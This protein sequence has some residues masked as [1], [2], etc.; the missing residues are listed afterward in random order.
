MT[1][2]R[3]GTIWYYDFTVRGRRYA[4]STGEVTK[5]KAQAVHD[6]LRVQFREGANI[7]QVWEQTKNAL[8]GRSAGIKVEPD[9]LWRHFTAHAM[10]QACARRMSQYRHHITEFAD[11]IKATHGDLTVGDITPAIAT[12]YMT[13]VRNDP[14]AP[15]SKNERLLALKMLFQSF[16][17]GQGVIENPFANIKRLSAPA[18]S[19]EIFSQDELQ[20]IGEKA[21]GSVLDICLT[22]LYTGLRRGDICNLRWSSV[23]PDFKWIHLDRMRKTGR[24]VDIPVMPRLQAHLAALPHTSEYVY[25]LLQQL[26]A[27]KPGEI[28]KMMKEFLR[29][30]GILGIGKNVEGY[31]RQ[32]SVKDIHSFRHTFVYLAACN[33]IPL[34]IVQSIVG[35]ASPAMTKIYMDHANQADKQRFMA[36][37]PDL[38]SGEQVKSPVQDIIDMVENDAPKEEIL[39]ALHALM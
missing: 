14:G 12:A 38:L 1:L 36:S 39:S 30:I 24:P 20:L 13:K 35:H 22:A 18:V 37:L 3:Q 5:T 17:E 6:R 10:S 32:L 4:G 28:S 26:Y 21:E 16:D 27:E 29:E 25:P 11:W 9:A 33:N 34:P 19:R 2:Y 31:A 23:S 7:R 8:L 15:A